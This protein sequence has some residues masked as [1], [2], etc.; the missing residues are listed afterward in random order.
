MA[1]PGGAVAAA[2]EKLALGLPDGSMAGG[3]LYV[4]RRKKTPAPGVLLVHGRWGLD[5]QI[6]ER[7][8]DL[9]E[10]GFLA[11]AADLFDG[12]IASDPV[13]A[14]KLAQSVDHGRAMMILTRWIDYLLADERGIGTVGV[15]GWDLGGGWAMDVSI[16][17]P[18][19][20]TVVYY[21]GGRK[22][23]GDIEQLNGPVLGHFARR[24]PSLP[25]AAVLALQTDLRLARLDDSEIYWYEAGCGFADRASPNYDPSADQAAWR[26][27]SH[28]LSRHLNP[29]L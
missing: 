29:H 8:Q 11:L 16:E 2:L 5:E 26:R 17:T 20:A 14:L 27:T 25:V 19:N 21:G 9:A 3:A 6:L 12:R 24:D 13:E 7:A 23:L 1:L 10:Q 22:S 15:V 4:P 18:V 28:F